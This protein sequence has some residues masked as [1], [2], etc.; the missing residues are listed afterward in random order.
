MFKTGESEKK[1]LLKYF[2]L[3]LQLSY[4]LKLFQPKKF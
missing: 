2:V 4:N 3:I 1:D